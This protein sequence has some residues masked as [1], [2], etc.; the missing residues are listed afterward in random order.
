MVLF[1]HQAVLFKD[2]SVI[3]WDRFSDAA[4]D[5]AASFLKSDS[6]PNPISISVSGADASLTV[7]RADGSAA[8][9]FSVSRARHKL[10]EGRFYIESFSFEE[11]FM[12]RCLLLAWMGAIHTDE[13]GHLEVDGSQAGWHWIADYVDRV[14]GLELDLATDYQFGFNNRHRSPASAQDA[15]MFEDLVNGGL[16]MTWRPERSPSWFF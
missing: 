10:R 16:L 8:V 11:D 12:L 2:L 1:E 7:N 5:L 15:K 9:V 3:Q 13:T 6:F 14:A 4:E